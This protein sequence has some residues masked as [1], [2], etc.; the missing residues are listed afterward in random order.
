MEKKKT[1]IDIVRAWKDPAYRK[2]LTPSEVASLPPN[3]AGDNQIEKEQLVRM[4]HSWV[5]FFGSCGYTDNVTYWSCKC[6]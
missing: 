3:P 5:E 6:L 1:R 2:G 4:V